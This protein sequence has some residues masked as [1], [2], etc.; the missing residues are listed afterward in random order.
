[1]SGCLGT[2]SLGAQWFYPVIDPYRCAG[3]GGPL[4]FGYP[5][6][7]DAVVIRVAPN[8]SLSRCQMRVELSTASSSLAETKQIQAFNY[9]NNSW[10][11]H[12]ETAAPGPATAM[13]IEKRKPGE[14][15]GVGTDTVV[16]ARADVF[17]PKAFYAFPPDDFWDFWGGRTVS[18]EWQLDADYF[19]GAGPIAPSGAQTPPPR[20]P[21][22][23]LPDRTLMRN[24]VGPGFRVVFGGTD[25]RTDDSIVV[26]GLRYLDAFDP[27][28]A[29]PF[30]PLPALPVDGTL[31]REWNRPEV[32]V[33][34]GGAKFW[35]PDPPTL[36]ALGFDW[37]RVGVIPPGGTGKLLATPV[38]GTLIKEQHDPRIF[39]VDGHQLRWVQSPAVMDAR[40]LPWRH[41]RIVPDNALATLPHGPDLT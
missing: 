41:V 16:L 32:Y 36:F 39:L 5:F 14:G 7:W 37:T 22:V 9:Y 34:Y 3:P 27:I 6:A 2:T 28:A 25:F 23:Q 15:C 1:M 4:A 17:G 31:V 29:V 18:F 21:V 20:Y 10:S 35:I 33:V 13:T 12:I 11:D 26:N 38:N 19:H 40:C 24:E 8:P 30:R